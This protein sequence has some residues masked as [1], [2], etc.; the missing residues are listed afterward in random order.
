MQTLDELSILRDT[1]RVHAVAG[2]IRNLAATL[3]ATPLDRA[4]ADQMV[5]V[6]TERCPPAREA[7]E[8]LDSVTASAAADVLRPG[9]GRAV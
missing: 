9:C 7:L 4:A 3:A 2:E 6:L 5:E 8:R 1:A